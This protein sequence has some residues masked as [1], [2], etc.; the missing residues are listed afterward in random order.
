MVSISL[1]YKY[2]KA[3]SL[4]VVTGA[5][6]SSL[7]VAKY[8]GVTLHFSIV[9]SLGLCVWLIYT[10]DHLWDARKVAHTAHSFRHRFH[11]RHFS[12]LTVIAILAAVMG[13]PLLRWLP[14]SV[15]YMGLLLLTLVV[16][17]FVFLITI[18][19]KPF[20]HKEFMIAFLYTG[21]IFLG[22]LSLYQGHLNSA[23]I[24]LFA[25]F[26]VLAFTNLV[27]FSVF[28][29]DLDL[30]DGH[31]SLATLI[32]RRKGRWL[33]GMLLI[34]SP[35]MAVSFLMEHHFSEKALWIQGI[36]FMMTAFLALV[37]VF[38]KVFRGEAYRTISDGIFYLPILFL[39]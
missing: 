10:F 12:T 4:D 26:V 3:L 33:I 15:F 1:F 11:Q 2:F 9:L 19:R 23:L 36:C 7:F 28:E 21:G 24:C 25:Q 35:V 29:M 34:L 18:G 8:L 30:R 32:G 6:I 14:I 5:C 37:M 17:Y 39:L 20:F 31:R 27:I 22:P 13:L 16:L 38:P